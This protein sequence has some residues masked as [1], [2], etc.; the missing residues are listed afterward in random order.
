[1]A[2]YY[3][4]TVI[5]PNIPAAALSPLERLLLCHI[6]EFDFN[7]RDQTYYFYTETSPSIALTLN[8]LTL[9]RAIGASIDTPSSVINEISP[10]L[11]ATDPTDVIIELDA[12]GFSW[13]FILQDIVK[14][15][16]IR[17]FTATT[18]YTCSKMHAD[19]F[20]GAVALITA[21]TIKGKSTHDILEEFL[22]EAR[23]NDVIS[24]SPTPPEARNE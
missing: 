12:S 8:R 24:E 13:E 17:Y 3:S 22:E 18:A 14:R 4:S 15:S 10:Q 11:H 6:F 9:V 19:G 20:G 7:E 1:M 2:D 21:E 23:L 5:D 16:S